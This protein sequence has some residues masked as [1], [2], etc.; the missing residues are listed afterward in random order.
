MFW[1][2]ILVLIKFT[3]AFRRRKPFSDPE[4]HSVEFSGVWLFRLVSSLERK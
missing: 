4:S 3:E 1:F 2:S